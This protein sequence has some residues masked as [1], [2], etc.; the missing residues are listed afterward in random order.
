MNRKKRPKRILTR[1]RGATLVVAMV[2]LVLIMMI[3]IAAV[4][5]SSTQSKLAGNLQFENTAMNSAEGAIGAAELW[6]STGT[7]FKNGGFSTYAAATPQLHPLGHLASLA[8]PANNALTMNWNG[9]SDIQAGG[10]NQR[11]M[12]ELLSTN[13]RLLGSSQAVG[14]RRS[15]TCQQVNTYMITARA[16][17]P[18]SATKFVQSYY[19]VLSC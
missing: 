3:G 14:Q 18:R 1:E 9:T 2:V 11:Y 5:S 8:A 16:Q 6:L 7:N 13:N 12:I 10:A 15:T 17:A 19:S 4:T